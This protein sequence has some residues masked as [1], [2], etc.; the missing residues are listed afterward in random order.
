[1]V[2]NK[3][4][5]FLPIKQA[6]ATCKAHRA[7]LRLINNWLRFDYYWID[8]ISAK[9][10]TK[11]LLSWHRCDRNVEYTLRR[12]AGC[13][14]VYVWHIVHDKGSSANSNCADGDDAAHS[15]LSS[16]VQILPWHRRHLARAGLPTQ[17]N[18][19]G[20]TPGETLYDYT[21]YIHSTYANTARRRSWH[22][23]GRQSIDRLIQHGLARVVV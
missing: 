9:F 20:R 21:E 2:W 16:T 18:K 12:D 17:R 5:N 19:N 4:N 11:T 13:T 3:R 14:H 15:P 6:L 22:F 7:L 8:L 23:L 10:R 1:M